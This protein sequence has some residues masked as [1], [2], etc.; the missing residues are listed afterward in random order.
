ME[1]NDRVVGWLLLDFASRHL[2]DVPKVNL[3]LDGGSICCLC[4]GVEEILEVAVEGV[5]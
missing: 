2:V 3:V 1:G 4:N 5:L